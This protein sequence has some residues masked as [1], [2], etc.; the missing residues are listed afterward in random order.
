VQGNVSET[1]QS[2]QLQAFWSFKHAHGIS[3]LGT[4]QFIGYFNAI[5]LICFVG[6]KDL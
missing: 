5:S 3:P 6:G 4:P 2:V 1:K